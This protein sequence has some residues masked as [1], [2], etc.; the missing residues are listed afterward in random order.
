[1]RGRTP[2]RG[3]QGQIIPP[4][5]V[6]MLLCLAFGLMMLQVGVAADYKSR[7]QTAA[8]AGALAGAI[9]VK[10][11]IIAAYAMD[12][13]LQPEEINMALVCAQAAIYAA[14]NRA[15]ITDCEHDQYDIK[16][17]VRGNDA[18]DA[19]GDTDQVK[20]DHAEAKA[21]ATPWSFGSGG[22]VLGGGGGSLPIGGGGGG[23]LMGAN[24]RM[25]VY[26]DVAAKKFNLHVSS[27]LRPVSITTNGN[28]S[29]HETGFAVDLNGATDD[30]LAFA[31]YAAEHW[32]GQ[33]EEL[34]HTPLGYGVKNGQ[35]V[36]LSFWGSAT[37]ADHFDHV[38]LADT[39]PP[40]ADHLN[41]GPAE[42]GSG[43]GSGGEGGFGGG[44]GGGGGF[45][46]G[47]FGLQVHLVRWD[48]QGGRVPDIPGAPDDFP[49]SLRQ[50]FYQLM[51]CESSG[52]PR[53]IEEPGGRGGALGHYGLFQFDIP[54]WES[55]GGH[56][57]PIDASPEEQWMR[58]YMLY[59][60]RGWQPWECATDDGLLNYA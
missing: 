38:H 30:M 20:G 45:G 23:S 13:Q 22:G 57:N 19:I 12:H 1:V 17:K 52:N 59:Q 35:Q 14:R 34:I 10:R 21:R 50:M 44:L 7:S 42:P 51:I 2:L 37:N 48:G 9:E 15:M 39:D 56:G 40:D 33:L 58:A 24:P 27:G 28:H 53:N 47:G 60:Q 25:S 32:G 26:V 41:G 6:I 54:T 31:K 4:L 46:L 5:L 36:P 49:A 29:L 18:L 11:E 16:V 3:E 55:V 43:A 8:D